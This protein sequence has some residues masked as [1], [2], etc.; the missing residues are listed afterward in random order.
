MVFVLD[1]SAF[2]WVVMPSLIFLARI[3]DV[4]L[5]TLRIIFISKGYRF[6]APVLGF[7]EVMVWLLAVRQIIVNVSSPGMYVAYGA[8]CAVGTFIGLYLEEWLSI[9]TVMIRV[10]TSRDSRKLLS[11]L[12]DEGFVVTSSGASGSDGKV[13]VLFIVL[14][15]DDI[16]EAVGI[17]KHFHPN[18]F[19]SI[20]DVRFVSEHRRAVHKVPVTA[21]FLFFRKGK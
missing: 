16:S 7:F 17:V 5:G 4:S 1:S 6:M 20:E 10:I 12:K 19:Y 3:V 18:A 15:R 14:E 13:G 21:R 8:G 9:G 2:T 11:A